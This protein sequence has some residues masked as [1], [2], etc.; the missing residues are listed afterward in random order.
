MPEIFLKSQR[1]FS[2]YR[3]TIALIG[4]QLYQFKNSP[5]FTYFS[6]L[7][8]VVKYKAGDDQR[9]SHFDDLLSAEDKAKKSAKGMHSTKNIPT[10]RIAD[11]AGDVN[12]SKQFLPFLQR[13]GRMQA[14]VEFIASGSRFRV[15]IP[16]YIIISS[17][18][19][20]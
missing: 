14:V 17:L 19:P 3:G 10:R 15:Y 16:R 7:A 12:K 13:A 11:L 20:S 1:F 6:G 18:N 9:S 5:F 4:D 8:T 2:K